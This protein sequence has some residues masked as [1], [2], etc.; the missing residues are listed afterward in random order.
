MKLISCHIEN[1]GGL[2]QFDMSF[3]DGLN[4]LCHENGFGKSTLAVFIK[5]MLY[6][7]QSNRKQDITANERK[8]Y[9]P[10]GGGVYGGTLDFSVGDHSYRIER[11]FGESDTNEKNDRFTMYDLDTGKP[12]QEM[13]TAPGITLFGVDADGFEKSLYISQRMPRA[14]ADNSSIKSKLG[15][16][17]EAAD[18]LGGFDEACKKLDK[19]SRFY[20]TVGGRGLIGDLQ[21]KL[22][23]QDHAIAA[24]EQAAQRA[25]LIQ[26]QIKQ[27]EQEKAQAEEELA[28][29]AKQEQL[30]R[31]T[32]Q[33]ALRRKEQAQLYRSLAD[34]ATASQ[35]QADEHRAALGDRLPSAEEM[36]QAEDHMKQYERLTIHLEGSVLSDEKADQLQS[37]RLRYEG[38]DLSEQAIRQAEQKRDALLQKREELKS[39]QPRPDAV[40]EQEKERFAHLNDNARQEV[41]VA[42]V[43]CE[44][45]RTATAP[46]MPLLAVLLLV[47]GIVGASA[48]LLPFLSSPLSLVV[49][50]IGCLMILDGAVWLL[51]WQLRRTKERTAMADRQQKLVALLQAY[52]G[53]GNSGEALLLLSDM[54]RYLEAQKQ[55]REQ[56]EAYR[57]V[58][59][60]VSQA[61][62]AFAQAMVV[63]GQG[64]AFAILER[65]ERD[66][67]EI[68]PLLNEEKKLLNLRAPYESQ[69]ERTAKQLDDFAGRYPV[70]K[71]DRLETV[72]QILQLAQQC[73]QLDAVAKK[74]KA[75]LAKFLAESGFDPSAPQQE[76]DET[77][78]FMEKKEA[79]RNAIQ[80][81]QSA[82]LLLQ[83]DAEEERNNAISEPL[84]AE[85][86]TILAQMQEATATYNSLRKT[87][88]LLTD[89]KEGL[90]TRYLGSM[91]N[92]F[93]AYMQELEENAIFHFDTDLTLRVEKGGER[94]ELGAMSAGER[95]MASFCARLSLIDSIFRQEKPML[96]LDDPFVNLDD[97]HYAAV[98]Q[99]LEQLAERMQILYFICRAEK[100]DSDN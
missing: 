77:D 1:F 27:K 67:A 92:S 84:K 17:L 23:E 28:L 3:A 62:E 44:T 9:R 48:F 89:A 11:F 19:A 83:R 93:A 58:E 13:G 69:L 47:L 26:E 43:A 53:T 29:L 25:L 85:R 71:A 60:E 78:P 12:C 63:Y 55:F 86:E 31:E 90:S 81:I 36:K 15:N 45:D 72:S 54:R 64:D 61:E 68:V 6:G 7:L 56:E 22:N 73:H 24:C 79:C 76:Q 37:L 98:R 91:E 42:Y 18:D 39:K 5:A 100:N 74:A 16:L 35:K 4:V 99:L 2:S 51:L 40:L 95:D 82:I 88:K 30:W 97:K 87:M 96:I 34:D 70:K 94:R 20:Q 59:Q 49:A 33:D 57:L 80:D 50:A 38:M 32:N 8:K 21:K 52:G 65:L 41:E 66:Y 10:W 14:S 75:T 46:K